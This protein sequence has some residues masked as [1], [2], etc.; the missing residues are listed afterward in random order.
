MSAKVGS[1][2]KDGKTF[3]TITLSKDEQVTQPGRDKYGFSF[4]IG[5]AKLIIQHIEEI[6][7]F[8]ESEG[9]EG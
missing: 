1:F 8:V 3:A 6:K 9:R 2:E 4:G 5:K 7:R